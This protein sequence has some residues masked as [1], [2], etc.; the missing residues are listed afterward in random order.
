MLYMAIQMRLS[1]QELVDIV[2]NKKNSHLCY[3]CPIHS[4]QKSTFLL[5]CRKNV[6]K[7]CLHLLIFI[8]SNHWFY[9]N[10]LTPF[11]CSSLVATRCLVRYITDIANLWNRRPYQHESFNERFV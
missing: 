3:F 5:Y 7:Q 9:S 10:M 2:F 4:L 8:G 6:L 1:E 11:L